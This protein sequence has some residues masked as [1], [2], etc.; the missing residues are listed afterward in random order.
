MIVPPLNIVAVEEQRHS[1]VK[2][3]VFMDVD[4]VEKL[5]VMLLCLD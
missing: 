5:L 1:T 4:T 3:C 2:Y